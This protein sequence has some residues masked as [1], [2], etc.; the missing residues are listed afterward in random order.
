[1]KA[2]DTHPLIDIDQ[3]RESQCGNTRLI[4]PLY[5]WTDEEVYEE[6]ELMGVDADAPSDDMAVSQE[7]FDALADWDRA[8][9]LDAFQQR[10]RLG[11][12]KD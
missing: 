6:L 8:S 5:D 10:F 7:V 11:G 4:A 9:S 1:M 2:C 12:Y 3:A